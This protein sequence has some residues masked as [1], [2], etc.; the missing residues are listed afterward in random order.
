MLEIYS[1]KSVAISGESGD[2]YTCIVNQN[3][4]QIHFS[5]C[6]HYA[7]GLDVS[8]KNND[9]SF[10][11]DIYHCGVYTKLRYKLG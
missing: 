9:T 2:V 5:K 1:F 8:S 4:G 11:R 7:Q 6:S 3:A 10:L